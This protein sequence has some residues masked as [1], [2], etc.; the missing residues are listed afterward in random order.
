MNHES[1]CKS[2]SGSEAR[3]LHEL[4]LGFPLKQ[5]R[6]CSSFVS[7]VIKKFVRDTINSIIE[8]FYETQHYKSVRIVINV[9]PI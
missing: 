3:F 6:F 1:V 9:D 5:R 7:D 2:V 4:A 8:K